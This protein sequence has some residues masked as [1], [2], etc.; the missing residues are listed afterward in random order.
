MCRVGSNPTA[1]AQIQYDIEVNPRILIIINHS[2]KVNLRWVPPI[3]KIGQAR[4]RNTWFNKNH[5]KLNYLNLIG[6]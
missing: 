3:N 4:K 5:N 6:I 2:S 1:S